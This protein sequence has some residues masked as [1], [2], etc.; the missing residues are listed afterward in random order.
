MLT[1]YLQVCFY[2][3][4]FG[5]V[6]SCC[7]DRCGSAV[8]QRC[9]MC[10][11]DSAKSQ[12]EFAVYADDGS[13]EYACCL[14]CV[15][16]LEKFMEPRKFIRIETRDFTTGA[17]ID[18]KKAYYLAAG[19]LIPKGSMAPFLLAFSEEDP[20]KQFQKKYKG[21]ILTFKEAMKITAKFDEEEER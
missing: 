20:A 18:A 4:S 3:L 7:G 2:T 15:Y 6:I 13:M 16:L 14:H 19:S 1:V 5:Q 21:S 8:N 10:G 12:T 11:M 9:H 17:F